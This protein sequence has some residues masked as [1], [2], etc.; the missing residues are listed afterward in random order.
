MAG[1]LVNDGENVIANT[2]FEATALQN[3]YV[4]LFSNN[5]TL[6]EDTSLSDLTE[7]AEA[8]GYAPILITRGTDWSVTGSVATGAQKTFTASG[9]AWGNVY[10]YFIMDAAKTTLLFAET[11]SDGPYNVTD[12]DSVKVTPV[13]TLS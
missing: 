5:F 13:V 4:G 9:A 11:F 6:A 8:N 3:L 2:L 10:G 7:L 12:G 1:F